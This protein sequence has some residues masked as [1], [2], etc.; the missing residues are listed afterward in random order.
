[1]KR[2]ILFRGK[3]V[4]NGEWLYGSLLI[5]EEQTLIVPIFEYPYQYPEDMDQNVHPKTVGQFTGFTDKNGNKIF[6]GDILTSN[7]YPYKDDGERNYDG[8][9]SWVF[10]GWQ[11][12]L[13]LVNENKRGISD[14]MNQGE[15]EDLESFEIIGN[16]HEK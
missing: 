6:E 5:H 4:D 7:N 16:I 2:E 14:R 9:V 8:I 11:L 10:N 15:I 1:M 3:R 13:K 12:V